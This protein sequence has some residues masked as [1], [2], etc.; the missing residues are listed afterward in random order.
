MKF[1]D[2]RNKR[3]AKARAR[4]AA[5]TIQSVEATEDALPLFV[6]YARPVIRHDRTYRVVN[7]G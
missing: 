5:T 3:E 4:R 7:T 6:G 1:R 2:R